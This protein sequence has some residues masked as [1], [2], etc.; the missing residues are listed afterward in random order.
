M[1]ELEKNW[2]RIA[3]V[4]ALPAIACACGSE[5]KEPAT[6]GMQAPPAPAVMTPPPA[7]PGTAPGAMAG[8]GALPPTTM[9]PATPGMQPA[10]NP[11]AMPSDPMT[12]APEQK[13]AEPVDPCKGFVVSRTKP[14]NPDPN[15]CKI[16]S[17]F[18]GDNY[19][20]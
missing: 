11:G 4:S 9:N 8:S 2:L 6:P 18:F 14:C 7:A 15:P 3:L 17:G 12:M 5:P 13:P 10:M 19:C 16:D 1:R 20:L